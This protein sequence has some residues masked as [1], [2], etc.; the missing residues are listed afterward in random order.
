MLD[1][2]EISSGYDPEPSRSLSLKATAYTEA[3]WFDADLKA[4]I[5]RSWQWVCHV[6]KTR[7]PGS[8]ITVEIAGSP[9]AVVRGRDGMLRACYNVCKHSLMLMLTLFVLIQ[10][11]DI[12]LAF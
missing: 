12:L 5:S 10:H 2:R 8:Y 9:I 3:S 7:E 11:M 1:T 4:I 6:E